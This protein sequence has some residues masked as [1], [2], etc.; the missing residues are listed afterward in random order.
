MRELT[1]ESDRV[2][3]TRRRTEEGLRVYI[4]SGAAQEN[5]AVDLLLGKLEQVAVT[6]RESECNPRTKTNLSLPVGPI[7]IGSP[8]KMRLKTPDEKLDT[9]CIEEQR[10]LKT[11]SW[12]MLSHLDTIQVRRVAEQS[13]ETLIMH[14]PMTV[15]SIANLNPLKSGLEELIAYLRV[16]K[17]VGAASQDKKESVELCDKQGKLLRASIPTFLLSADL[18]P[19]NLDELNF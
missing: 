16:A 18:F 1:Y 11:P 8:E 19:E 12:D 15:A 7:K 3:Q 14:G 10:N 17:A 9:S 13:L 6:L 2:F 4:E 5:R